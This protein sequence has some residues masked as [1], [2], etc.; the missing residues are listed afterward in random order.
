[1]ALT[2]Q[3]RRSGIKGGIASALANNLLLALLLVSLVPLLVLGVTVYNY[4]SASLDEQAIAGLT[5]SRESKVTQLE[6]Y[7]GRIHEQVKTF[8]EDLM[9]IDAMQDFSAAFNQ[10]TTDADVDQSQLST[11]RDRLRSFYAAEFAKGYQAA[12]SETLELDSLIEPLGDNAIY[13]QHQFIAANPYPQGQ[14]DKLTRVDDTTGYSKLHEKYHP[15]LS[16]FRQAFGYYDIFLVDDETGNIVY[17]VFKEID[18]AT[19]LREGPYSNTNFDQVYTQALSAGWSNYVAFADYQPYLPSFDNPASFI[20]SP[21]FKD[22]Q[23]I[24][25]VVFQMPIDRIDTIMTPTDGTEME[26]YTIGADSLLRNNILGENAAGLLRDNVGTEAS[27][28]VFS[29]AGQRDGVGEFENRLGELALA[30]WGPV[31]VHKQGG[32]GDAEVTWGLIAETPLRV[33]HAPTRRIFWFTAAVVAVS[34]LLVLALSI[35]ISRRFTTHA[36]RQSELVRGIAENTTTLASA[37][38]ELSSVSEQM[39]AAAE[40]TTAQARVVSEASDHVS[41]NTRNVADGLESFSLSVREVA[42]SA[43][44]AA[45]VANRAVVVASTADDSIK[46][47]GE[48]S[49]R[50]GEIVKVITTIAE[51]TNLAGAERDD[52]GGARG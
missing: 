1:M 12:T 35:A 18:F 41:E 30:S 16:D 48:S 27:R 25:V 22:G 3:S 2:D 28:R 15:V 34:A 19:S 11:M 24:G 39:S 26:T 47:L 20:A 4:A 14:K 45:N 42:S 13:L 51:Q 44:E 33:V 37:S 49:Q 9:V 31:T 43:S 7:F 32:A 21:I 52:R 36:N 50:I 5:D 10:V 38:E 23:R 6:R 46:K 40:E 17:S 29:S 8:S